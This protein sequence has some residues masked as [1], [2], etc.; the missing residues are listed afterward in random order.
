MDESLFDK[1]AVARGPVTAK[2]FDEMVAKAID[3][4]PEEF[5]KEFKNVPVV[6]SDLGQDH[7]AYGL[8]QGDGIARD[9]YPDR[10]LIFR[11]TLIRDFG[12]DRALLAAQVERTVRHELAHHFGF[13]EGGVRG[14]GL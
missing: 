8:Y 4:I 13:N 1:P 5:S 2:E 12:H 6:V 9:N 11:D 7:H 10:I 3:G 14:L